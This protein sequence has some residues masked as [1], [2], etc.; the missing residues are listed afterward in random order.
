MDA[1]F[2]LIFYKLSATNLVYK[3]AESI[4][5]F[6]TI[7]TIGLYLVYVMS[8]PEDLQDIFITELFNYWY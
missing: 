4:G 1:W 6:R 7:H 5:R 2:K 8:C 3:I